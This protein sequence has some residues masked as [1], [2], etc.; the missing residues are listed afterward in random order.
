[1]PLRAPLFIIKPFMVLVAVGPTKAPAEVT[2]PEPVVVKLPVVL[3]LMSLAKS[4]P[5]TLPKEG[6]PE[7]LP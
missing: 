3:I 4:E 5:V 6:T 7:A 2:T 1:M